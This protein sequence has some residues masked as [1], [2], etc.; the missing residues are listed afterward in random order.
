V[1]VVVVVVA[2]SMFALSPPPFACPLPVAP[3][4]SVHSLFLPLTR[5]PTSPPTK[6]IAAATAQ[7]MLCLYLHH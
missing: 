5:K 3:P 6:A 4:C 2:A 7:T 1:V